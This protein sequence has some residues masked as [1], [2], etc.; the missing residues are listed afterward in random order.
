MCSAD[1]ARMNSNG[2]TSVAPH[3]PRTRGMQW[4]V[5]SP[6]PR[7]RF[8]W[9]RD[10]RALSR[11]YAACTSTGTDLQQHPHTLGAGPL[12][13][14]LCRQVFDQPAGDEEQ[15]LAVLDWGLQLASR[16]DDFGRPPETEQSGL[17]SAGQE[18]G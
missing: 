5:P 1:L 12:Q 18:C 2:S 17:L 6:C 16:S 9:P 7:V 15:R 8:R 13:A 11:E 14:Q 3:E 4:S 10:Q